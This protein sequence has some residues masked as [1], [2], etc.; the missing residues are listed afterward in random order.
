M[1][2]RY[3][4][5]INNRR[6]SELLGNRT[7]EKA[8]SNGLDLTRQLGRTL[9]QPGASLAFNLHSP[10]CPVN[11]NPEQEDRCNGQGCAE[12]TIRVTTAQSKA[13]SEAKV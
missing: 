10:D 12:I 5:T 1:A 7:L 11:R 6:H 13:K 2:Y 8:L 9:L 4:A 3:I